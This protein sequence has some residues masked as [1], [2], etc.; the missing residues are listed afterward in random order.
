MLPQEALAGLVIHSLYSL[1]ICGFCSF[2]TSP[3]F[4][5]TFAALGFHPSTKCSHISFCL[6]LCFLGNSGQDWG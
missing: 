2:P 5:F 1:Y 3:P 6:R 4:S